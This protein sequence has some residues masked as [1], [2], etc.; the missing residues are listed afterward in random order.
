MDISSSNNRTSELK[1]TLPNLSQ[2]S[3]IMVKKKKTKTC[4]PERV[5]GVAWISRLVR[6]KVRAGASSQPS[7]YYIMWH[8]E[9]LQVRHKEN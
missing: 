8:P 2:I 5:G 7:A 1:D 6:V 3:Q 4:A 9:H